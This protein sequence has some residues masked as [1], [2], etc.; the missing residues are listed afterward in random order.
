M[1][2]EHLMMEKIN[3]VMKATQTLNPEAA[4]ASAMALALLERDNN[5]TEQMML[6]KPGFSGPSDPVLRQQMLLSNP[7][8]MAHHD[9]VGVWSRDLQKEM[10]NQ[11]RD[12]LRAQ[13]EE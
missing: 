9:K 1:A 6:E 7:I 11:L 3:E 5:Q 2:P 13:A 12:A 4:G 8:G 10:D